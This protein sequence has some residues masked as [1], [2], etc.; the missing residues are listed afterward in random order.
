M[1]VVVVG[2]SKDCERVSDSLLT[3]PARRLHSTPFVLFVTS[4]KRA[5]P[6]LFHFILNF[7]LLFLRLFLQ[8]EGFSL[9]VPALSLVGNLL[10][11]LLPT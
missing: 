11:T 1:V 3:S 7:F 8:H 9:H 10:K 2:G 4:R 5:K 6:F